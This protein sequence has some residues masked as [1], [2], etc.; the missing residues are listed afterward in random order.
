MR[1]QPVISSAVTLQ[2]ARRCGRVAGLDSK[3]FLQGMEDPNYAK[4]EASVET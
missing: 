4:S 2:V 3:Y 1:P